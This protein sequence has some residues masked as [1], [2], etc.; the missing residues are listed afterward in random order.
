MALNQNIRLFI[1]MGLLIFW[2]IVG[3][4][5]FKAIEGWTMVDSF[6][7]SII[8]ISTVGFGEVHPLSPGGRLFASFMIVLG[9]GTALYTLSRVG[10]LILEGELYEIL[11][12]RKMK[13]ELDK[14]EGHFIVCGFGRVGEPVADGLKTEGVPFCVIEAEPELERDLQAKGHIYLIGD[15]TDEEVLEIAGIRKAR[16]LLALL[17]SDADNLY[18]TI[19]AR[20]MNSTLKIIARALDEKAEVRLERGGAD[21]VVSPYKM[22]G[23]RMIHAAVRPTVVEFMEL[24]TQR[25]QLE[26]CMEEITVCKPSTFDGLSIADAEIRQRFGLVIIAIKKAGGDMIFNPEPN[27]IIAVDDILVVIGRD[28]DLKGFEKACRGE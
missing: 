9:L 4:L 14:L 17:A 11:G 7:M 1:G 8:T 25:E 6:Y 18:L 3:A 19:A 27:V 28:S 12:R 23:L 22:A 16:S 5:G 13:Q 21:K 26:L 20:E 2:V 15:A 24:V 10:Q